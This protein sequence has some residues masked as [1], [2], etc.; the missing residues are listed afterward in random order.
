MFIIEE[1]FIEEYAI[2]P[3]LI[4]NIKSTLICTS[5][6]RLIFKDRLIFQNKEFNLTNLLI[7]KTVKGIICNF[8]IMVYLF[9]IFM[10]I[11]SRIDE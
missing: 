8:V 10:L 11:K 3:I 1:F 5:I 9:D 6:V 7:L 2:Q 4:L